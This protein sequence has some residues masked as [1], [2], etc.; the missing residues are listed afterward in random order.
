MSKDAP[1]TKNHK[2][3][4]ALPCFPGER[5]FNHQTILVSAVDKKD[6]VS[7]VRYLKPQCYIGDIKEVCY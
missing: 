2:Y 1:T 5:G 7:L 6:A 4:V 3:V